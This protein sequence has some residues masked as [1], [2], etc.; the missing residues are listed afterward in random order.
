MAMMAARAMPT[1]SMAPPAAPMGAPMPPGAAPGMKHG[2]LSKTHHK[3]LAHHHLA[4]AEHHMAQH[5]G[6]GMKH[7][8]KVHKMAHGGVTEKA[9]EMKQAKQLRHLA[10]EE[11]HEAKAMKHGG[12]A[13]MKKMAHGGHAESMGP[14]GMNEDVEKGSNK[15]GAHGESK[16]QKTGHTRG[17]NLGDSGKDIGIEGGMKR[18]GHIKKMAHG[19]S[20]SS[21]ADGIAKRGHTKTK[22]C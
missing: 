19:G 17:K 3:H 7:G 8:G 20:T 21:R 2:G 12:K 13:H 9:H 4:M 6:H 22:Y 10:S 11:E 5:E 15:H 16:V 14:R 1:P 18:G